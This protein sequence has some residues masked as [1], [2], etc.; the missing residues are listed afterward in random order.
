[1][2]EQYHFNERL[3]KALAKLALT[4][5]TAVQQKTIPLAMQGKDLF[6]TA[7]TGTGKTL[8]YVL[9]LLQL[10]LNTTKPGTGLQALVI[11]PTRELAT[12]INKTIQQVASYTFFHSLLVTG[13]E[14]LREQAAKLRKNPDIVVG[15]P[16][17]LAEHWQ[18]QQFELTNLKLLVLDE[19]D[20]ILDMGFG[21][22]V[23]TIIDNCPA[24][25]Q[26]LLLSA[27]KGN[28]SLQ[29][30]SEKLLHNPVNIH[31]E[32]AD[33]NNITQQMI[34]ADNEAHKKRL[35]EWLLAHESYQKAIIFTNTRAQA[36]RLSKTFSATQIK[37]TVLHSDKTAEE[38]KQTI[39]RLHQN[40][41]TILIATDVAA[42]GLDIQGIDLVINFD[43]PNT[44]DEYIHRIGRTGRMD[45]KGLAISLIDEKNWKLFTKIEQHL[46]VE[47]EK[48]VIASLN[49]KFQGSVQDKPK[50]DKKLSQA[51]QAKVKSPN[52]TSSPKSKGNISSVVST[53]GF[54]PLKR[55]K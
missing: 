29:I 21:D 25:K 34:F 47:V 18:K 55:K 16:G 37:H 54:A 19:T 3:L 20:R 31:L 24:N 6:I 23:T 30:L 26:T 2:F 51:K 45:N 8:S 52:K 41:V 33:K 38:R 13:G 12:Q 9:P 11:A 32:E 49:S 39:N 22:D 46:Q 17:R 5:P 28:K 7:P 15:T 44:T 48:R 53:D 4:N 10:L 14:G 40:H 36:D 27:T 1:M 43:L 42:R 50:S 35:I